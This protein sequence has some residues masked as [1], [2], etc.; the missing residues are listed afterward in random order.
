MG[1]GNDFFYGLFI[2]LLSLVYYPFAAKLLLRY[3]SSLQVLVL[4]L[5]I[6]LFIIWSSLGVGELLEK[7]QLAINNF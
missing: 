7:I 3:L 4:K 5:V 6:G 2:L 1:W